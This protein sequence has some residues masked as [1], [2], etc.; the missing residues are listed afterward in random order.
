MFVRWLFISLIFSIVLA[1]CVGQEVKTEIETVEP[2][3]E[4]VQVEP[5]TRPQVKKKRRLPPIIILVSEA[6]PAYQLVAD[7]LKK[8]FP[9]RSTIVYLSKDL[10]E[11]EQL[12]SLLKKPHYQQF[13]AIGLDAAKEAKGLTGREDEL[14]FCQVF[15]YQ[16]Y[17]LVGPAAK[18][19]ESLPGTAD[20]FA[21]WSAMSPA[22]K[23][24]VVIT[25]SGMEDYITAATQVAAK[26]GIELSHRVVS[27]DKEL[28]FVYKQVAP[29]VQ[30]LWLLPDNRV[31]SG[32]TIRELMTFSVRNAKQVVVFNESLLR[33]GGLMSVTTRPEEIARKVAQ[34]LRAAVEVKGVPGPDL[35]PL[36]D[37][38]I[39][40]NKVAARR[41]NIK[42]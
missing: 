41:Y 4:V 1:G 21:R 14:I 9:K 6:I 13:V 28:L 2:V 36:D 29:G 33:L 23:S 22:L 31:L 5:E 8:Q 30:G 39:K 11:R 27:T 10:K 35:L 34:R 37:A 20:M 42:L 16:N 17:Q 40:V 24:V 12:I 32:R 25:G 15:N 7:E 26:S 19:V 3:P 38:E 18:G